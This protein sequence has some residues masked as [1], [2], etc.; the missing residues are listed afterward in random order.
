MEKQALIAMLNRDLAD[1]HA[2]VLR[3]LE[4]SYLEGEDTPLGAGLLS[5]CREEMWHMHWLG[6]IIGQLGGEPD[7]TPAPYPYDPTNR[8]TILASY[9]AYEEKLIPH[10]L[11]EARQMEDPHIQRVLKRESWES[12]VHAKKF[13]R[14]RKKLT[15]ELATGLPGEENELPEAFLES[16]QGAVS[17]KYTQMLQTIR[18]S[19]V[20]QK[21][22]MMSWRMMDF[23]FTNMKQLAHVA[24]D[25]A[26]NG[27]APRFTSDPMV[28][29][30]AIGAALSLLTK[31]LTVTREGHI[32]LQNNPEAQKHQG[33]LINLD[34]SIR[35]EEYEIDEIRD[36]EK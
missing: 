1:E 32:A 9:V 7:M 30:A 23:A 11:E 17:R 5:R 20:L 19:W 25:V 22:G 33:L 15:R 14:T 24:E 27:V 3:Y 36:W 16:L 31:S 26:E 10:Y 18:D 34:L 21:D 13:E 28:Q 6:M 4:H 12:E 2:A 29:S 8:D 35:Q